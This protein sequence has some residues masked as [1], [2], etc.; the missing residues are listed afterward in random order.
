MMRL[1]V[2]VTSALVVAGCS[3]SSRMEGIAPG[4][5]NSHTDA[6]GNHRQARDAADAQVQTAGPPQLPPSEE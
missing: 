3:S 5:A 4:W 1:A 2:L 6:P